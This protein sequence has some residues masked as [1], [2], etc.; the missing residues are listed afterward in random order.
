MLDEWTKDITLEM[1]PDGTSKEIAEVIGLDNLLR[2]SEQF[3][4]TEI[5][6]P[7][8]D[9]ILG[10]LR[11]KLIFQEFNGKNAAALAKKFHI[12]SRRIRDIASPAAQIAARNKKQEDSNK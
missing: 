5:Y 11:N 6:I 9:R 7:K 1:L 3:G 10:P 12:S 2:F 8:L 4:G